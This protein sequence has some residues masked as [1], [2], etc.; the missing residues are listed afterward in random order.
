MS[1]ELARVVLSFASSDALEIHCLPISQILVSIA[2]HMGEAASN[3]AFAKNPAMRLE[4]T[5][6][7][8][9]T[10]G[11]VKFNE[12]RCPTIRRHEIPGF[13]SLSHGSDVR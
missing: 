10:S 8:G 5:F 11:K 13:A 6:E 4:A 12:P 1:L 7:F 2:W 9:G 3:E